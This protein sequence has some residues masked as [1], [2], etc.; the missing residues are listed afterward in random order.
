M[1]FWTITRGSAA[2]F[3]VAAGAAV[4]ETPDPNALAA[5]DKMGTELRTHQIFDVKSD[6]TME[7]VLGSGQKLQYAGTLEVQ[8]RRP[9]A[10]KIAMVS[11]Q[12]NREI[13]YNG[14]T[15]TVFSPR[16]GYYASFPGSDTIAKTLES[17]KDKYGIELPLADLFAWGVDKSL[18]ARVKSG[19]LVGPEHIG[20]RACNHYAFRQ[21]RV[22]WQIWIADSG[23]ALPCKLVI[24]STTDPAMPQY[25]AVMH[26]S[27]PASIPDSVFA[28]TPPP[29]AKKIVMASIMGG[30]TQ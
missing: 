28:F 21:E 1:S 3:L 6:V 22:D 18:T 25:A 9:T 11:D 27:F 23:P 29:T 13:Y 15:V 14:K 7:D 19:F 26:W 30:K 10:F 20:D 17:A 5:L 24:T 2:L 8:A 12:K 4:A 16:L